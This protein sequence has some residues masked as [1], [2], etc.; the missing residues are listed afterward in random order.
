VSSQERF[1]LRDCARNIRRFGA[2]HF[3]PSGRSPLTYFFV[4]LLVGEFEQAVAYLYNADMSG[5]HNHKVD[6]VHFG[7]ALA[8]HHALSVPVTP[9][10][11]DGGL[12]LLTLT[13]DDEQYEKTLINFAHVL[14]EYA[15][16]FSA[17]NPED[18]IQ[19]LLLVSDLGDDNTD[20]EAYVMQARRYIVD[21][22]VENVGM[23]ERLLGSIRQDGTRLPGMVQEY[24]NL[25]GITCADDFHA[26][27]TREA[28]ATCDYS[29]RYVDSIK[30][31]DL[32]G[33]QDQAIFT[34][35][36]KRLGEDLEKLHTISGPVHHQGIRGVH[37]S[38]S[39]RN[40]NT[41]IPN[42]T[43]E[44]IGIAKEILSR[45]TKNTSASSR[46]CATFI[47]LFEFMNLYGMGYH[48]PAINIM[49][50]LE[51]FP[52]RDDGGA[53]QSA[54]LISGLDEHVMRSLPVIIYAY[55]MA[56]GKL[57]AS[58]RGGRM[59][60]VRMARLGE[61]KGRAKALLMFTAH[62]QF[63]LSSGMCEQGGV[64]L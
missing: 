17:T 38:P 37:T 20:T 2:Q 32:A 15:R 51:I 41:I 8:H 57:H 4:L 23:V 28:A 14:N 30:L 47:H 29:G 31:Y 21:I 35:L 19:Y 63:K 16:A 62:V 40:A 6:A 43:Q 60:G 26:A 49:D 39:K 52:R 25:I 13:A 27:I 34:I 48:D 44:L 45:Y 24:G 58:C 11:S 56:L 64:I 18:A 53:V 7:V 12:R 54:Q 3:S 36:N 10:Q 5:Q 55:M 33:G 46:G 59:D 42:A 22:V 50:E 1:S 61:I 9:Q